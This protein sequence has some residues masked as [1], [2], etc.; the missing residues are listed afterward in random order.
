LHRYIYANNDPVNRSDPSGL[1]TIGELAFASAVAG[2][3]AGLGTYKVTGSLEKA[4]IV[5]GV[6]AIVVFIVGYFFIVAPA[7]AAAGTGA[8]AAAASTAAPTAAAAESV[9][10]H[11]VHNF[12]HRLGQAWL[13]GG[14]ITGGGHTA[15][16]H[17]ILRFSIRPGSNVFLLRVYQAIDAYRKTHWVITAPSVRIFLNDIYSQIG[18]V[19]CKSGTLSC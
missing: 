9:T 14:G 10:V 4:V 17:I 1:L 6:V 11:G 13:Q 3:L 18:F 2:I 16:A 19:L 5:A 15:T 8:P 7:A 12:I